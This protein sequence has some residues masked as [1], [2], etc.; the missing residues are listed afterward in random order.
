MKYLKRE[1]RNTDVTRYWMKVSR[2]EA[3]WEDV[4]VNGN[5][6]KPNTNLLVFWWLKFPVGN[7]R[8]QLE[9]WIGI[10]VFLRED[11]FSRFRGWRTRWLRCGVSRHVFI[12]NRIYFL[13]F[14]HFFL[15]CFVLYYF[16]FARVYSFYFA[17]SYTFSYSHTASY[18]RW[19]TNDCQ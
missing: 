9:T 2:E 11:I 4:D 14:I 17:K 7:G 15:T 3:I 1:T 12:K 18:S 6:K 10:N 13:F 5:I 19:L 16:R 8:S